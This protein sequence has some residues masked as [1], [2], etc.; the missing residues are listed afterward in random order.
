MQTEHSNESLAIVV[1]SPNLDR[2]TQFLSAPHIPDGT[3]GSMKDTLMATMLV[4][5]IPRENVVGMWWDMTAS[6]TG[7]F[8]GSVI[9]LNMSWTE[10]SCGLPATTTL[11]S[12]TSNTQM[13]I[14]HCSNVITYGS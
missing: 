10:L 9:C 12:C 3:G 14:Q 11:E 2:S 8:K 7:H 6:K 5:N 13:L 4:W 1:S